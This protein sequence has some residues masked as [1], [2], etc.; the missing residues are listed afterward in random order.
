MY[1]QKRIYKGDGILLS[2]SFKKNDIILTASKLSKTYFN[3]V[4]NE[5][6]MSDTSNN[7]R[8]VSKL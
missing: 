6:L 2:G 5:L 4:L 3:T 1:L 7:A 8:G